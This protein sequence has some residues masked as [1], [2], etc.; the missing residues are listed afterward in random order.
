[1][2]RT[3]RPAPRANATPSMSTDVAA[4]LAG[5]EHP[6]EPE[7]LAL[8][9]LILGAHP[10]IREGIKW[11]APSYH[12]TEHFATF[13]L[14]GKTGVQIVLHLGAKARPDTRVRDAVNDPGGLLEWRSHDRA[15]VSFRD[16]ADI[17]EKRAAFTAILRQWLEHV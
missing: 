9:A 16:L 13:H 11:N 3:N 7:I 6:R 12:T 5:L 10:S 14:R 4:L 17:E 8:R 1:M 15:L 2:P